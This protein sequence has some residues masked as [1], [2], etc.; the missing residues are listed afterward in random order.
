MK[1]LITATE[2]LE[3]FSEDS[4]HIREGFFLSPSLNTNKT[5]KGKIKKDQ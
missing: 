3:S 4:L 5:K 2:Y 1:K